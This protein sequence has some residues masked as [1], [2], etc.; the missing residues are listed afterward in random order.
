MPMIVKDNGNYEFEEPY[1]IHDCRDSINGNIFQCYQ[2]RTDKNVL[3]LKI[4]IPQ[5][6]YDQECEVKVI[7]CPFCG[8]NLAKGANGPITTSRTTQ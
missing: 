4:M 5:C 7:Y 2:R 8:Y 6:C 3:N 1:L